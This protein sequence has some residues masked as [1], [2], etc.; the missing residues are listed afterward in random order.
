M[1][2]TTPNLSAQYPATDRLDTLGRLVR[3]EPRPPRQRNATVI[4]E[5]QETVAGKPANRIV[6]GIRKDGAAYR[7]VL[8]VAAIG[9]TGYSFHPLRP[10]RCVRRARGRPP[11]RPL[12]LPGGRGP[13][14]ERGPALRVPPQAQQPTVRAPRATTAVAKT[15]ARPGSSLGN[16]DIR[17]RRKRRRTVPS[18]LPDSEP[19]G[20]PDRDAQSRKVGRGVNRDAMSP[21]VVRL[22]A[23][24]VRTAGTVM[25]STDGR[26]PA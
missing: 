13:L 22:D 24:S 6:T 2:S 19:R 10:T 15:H 5:R 20:D 23:G 21:T 7:N 14:E 3:R 26:R 17:R 8:V 1:V 12:E 4:E 16:P 18:T 25:P 9:D 11:D